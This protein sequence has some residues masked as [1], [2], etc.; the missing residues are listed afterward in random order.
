[1]SPVDIGSCGSHA[2]VTLEQNKS[3]VV[4]LSTCMKFAPA[5]GALDVRNICAGLDGVFT[6]PTT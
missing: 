2:R 1:M 6:L 3:D 4:V 5:S